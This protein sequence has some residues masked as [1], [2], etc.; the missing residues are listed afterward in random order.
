MR[1]RHARGVVGVWHHTKA[2]AQ[3]LLPSSFS[4]QNKKQRFF[5]HWYLWQHTENHE[6]QEFGDR[7][8]SLGFGAK[9]GIQLFAITDFQAF[10]SRFT[11]F[12]ALAQAMTNLHGH[13]A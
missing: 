6:I 10:V 11:F 12:P 4:Q 1:A 7:N 9:K 2:D 8:C 13:N 3:Q 5:V